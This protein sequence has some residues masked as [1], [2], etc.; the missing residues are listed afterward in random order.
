MAQEGEGN[1][2]VPAAASIVAFKPQ[3][4]VPAMKADEA[5]QFY[6]EAFGAE[7]LK[8][9]NHPKRKAEQ[10]APLILCAEL[11]IGSSFLLVCDQ[12]EDDF[13]AGGA[14]VVFRVETE[15]VEGAVAK[16]VKAGG[17]L[18]GE[19]TEEESGC[20]WGLLGKVK[21]PFGVVWYVASTAKKC[22][23]AEA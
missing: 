2:A 10:E 16:A 12:T 6:K 14:G 3:L 11:K 22:S 23:P 15:D 17:V 18:Q 19:I 13:A 21:D 1:G 5:V 7:E 4:L 20:G 8:R 9:M